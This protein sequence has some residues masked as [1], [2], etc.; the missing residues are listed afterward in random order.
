KHQAL[1]EQV[2]YRSNEDLLREKPVAVAQRFTFQVADDAPWVDGWL[3]VSDAHLSGDVS[4]PTVLQIHG[5]PNSMY[6]G[7]F[8]FEFQLLVSA[9]YAVVFTN[10]RGSSGYGEAFRTA[11]E[12]GWGTVDYQDA[13][14]EGRPLHRAQAGLGNQDQGHPLHGL[15]TGLGNQDQDHPL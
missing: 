15:Q 2:L 14:N 3:L 10:P 11:I 5:G 8:F 6:T 4:V 12:P 13:Q 9:G 1:D 7:A